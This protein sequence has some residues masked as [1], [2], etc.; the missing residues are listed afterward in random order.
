MA[1]LA[2]MVVLFTDFG[3]GGPYV[4]QMHAALQRDAPG[5][6]VIDLVNDAPRFDPVAGAY[7]LAALV[8]QIADDAV[9]LA[10]VD[11]GV[12]GPRAPVMARAG[13]RWL[14]GP[15]NGLMAIAARDAET[16]EWWD[17]TPPDAA[18]SPSFHG[19]DLFAPV[20]AGLARG[21]ALT[22][23]RRRD[24]AHVGRDWPRDR[25]AVIYVD[26]YGNVMTGLRAAT[27]A[28]DRAIGAAS[29]AIAPART[30]SDVPPGTAIWY[31]NSCGLVEIA[32][33]R[34]RADSDLGLAVGSPVTVLPAAHHDARR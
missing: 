6:P 18:L 14:V 10:V 8:P 13:R 15:D 3:P 16:A 5:T 32:V 20:G 17:I 11:P 22:G 34:G 1:A 19:R 2:S 4:G 28:P 21:G 27:V 7:L 26:P 33:N 24:G 23:T 12:G 31:E 30:F 9:V 25:A 29:R